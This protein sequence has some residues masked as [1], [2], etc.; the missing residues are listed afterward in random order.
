MVDVAAPDHRVM[1]QLAFA[2]P[3]ALWLLLAVPLVW[4][5]HLAARTN[6]NARQRRVQAAVRSLIVA[7]LAVALAR[8]VI[9]TR[10]SRESI[11]YAVDVSQSM[12]SHAIEEAAKRI[13]DIQ[14]TVH[15]AHS[16]IVAFGATAGRVDGT[17]ALRA[18]AKA[19]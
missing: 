16:R 19:D 10:S 2:V 13:D 9:S 15:P 11:V 8:P 14:A 1:S 6:F 18:L 4:L 5:A 3:S 12:G 17:A 7:L